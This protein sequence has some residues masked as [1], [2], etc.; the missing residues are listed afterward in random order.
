MVPLKFQ[1]LLKSTLWGGDKIIPFKHLHSTQAQVGESWEVSGVKDMESVVDGGPYAG[2]KLNDMI[3]S[4]KG[5]LVGQH[6]YERFGVEFPI[7]VKLIDARDQLSIQVHPTDNM[8][9]KQGHTCGKTEMWYIMESEPGAHLLS[10]LNETITPQDYRRMVADKSITQAIARHEVSKG[11]VFFLP[12]GRIHSIGSGCF[13]VEIQQTSDVTYRIYDFD[14]TD[15]QGQRRQLHTSEAAQCIDY[16]VHDDYRT[17]YKP[18]A[19]NRV[20]LVDCTYFTTNIINA[21]KPV[22]LNYEQLDSFVLLIAVGGK[23]AITDNE[24]NTVALNT[25]ET[26]LIPATTQWIQTSGR[27][28]LLETYV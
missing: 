14:R 7:L 2:R 17:H 25:G 20:N 22:A 27:M 8:A 9:R 13:L 28:R 10:G 21:S 3:H 19:N 1:P 5:E 15:N 18:Q 23:G 11:D 16:T 4:F 6:N 12:A 26:V 24:G